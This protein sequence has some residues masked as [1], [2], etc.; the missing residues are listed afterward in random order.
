D[1]ADPELASI[2]ADYETW[3]RGEDPVSAGMEGDDEAKSQLWDAS[4]EAEVARGEALA[5][6]ARRLDAIDPARLNADDALNHAFLSRDIDMAIERISLDVGRL[7]F[8]SEGGPGQMFG[9][10]A[11]STRI[12]S[13]SDAEAYISRLEAAPKVY[14]DVM[15]SARRGLETGLVQPRSTVD[16]A[17]LLMRTEAGHALD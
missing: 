9:Y 3:E 4:R 11:S 10:L 13:R 1:A 2:I 14:A 17:L 16:N 15:A 12:T 8:D 5:G 6:F 7:A